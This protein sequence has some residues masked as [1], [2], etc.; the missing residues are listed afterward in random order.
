M[1]IGLAVLLGIILLLPALGATQVYRWE[2]QDALHFTNT[3]ERVPEPHRTQVG[4]RL[5]VAPEPA[6]PAPRTA[7]PTSE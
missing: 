2:D 3:Y 4:P 7:T 1:R 5:P 6:V